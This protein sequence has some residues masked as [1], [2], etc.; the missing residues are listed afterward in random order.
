MLTLAHWS[1]ASLGRRHASRLPRVD[2]D[3]A[4]ECAGERLEAGFGNVVVVAAVEVLDMQRDAGIG[5]QRLK[6]LAEQFG[7]EIAD[8][9][10]REGHLPDQKRPSRYVD[11]AAG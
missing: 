1:E 9:R 4:A 6:E 5:R 8:P 11:R 2:R 10:P 3:C 7:V